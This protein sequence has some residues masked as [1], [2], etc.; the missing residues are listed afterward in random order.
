MSTST[1]NVYQQMM[2]SSDV[3]EIPRNTYQRNLNPERVKRMSADFD[4]RIANEPKVSKRNGKYYVFDGQHIIAARVA[5]NEGKATPIRCK[6]FKG[7]NEKDEAKLFANQTG[8]SVAPGIGV[9]LRALVFA[10]DPEAVNFVRAT[11]EA[12]LH[13]DF[14]QHKGKYRLAC[15]AAALTEYRKLGHE[16]YKEALRLI[17]E[18]WDGDQ[19]SLR[20]ETITSV[21]RFVDLYDG[22]Y[23][24]KRLV[25]RFR[26]VD[27]MKI[28]R[29][30]R[31]LGFNMPGYKKYL[32]QV[33]LIYNGSSRKT[34]LPIKF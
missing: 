12:G 4:E 28:Y 32:Y 33:L 2:L 30:G 19:D 16:K 15:I 24:P 25:K 10:E 11:E 29:D 5:L 31:A 22:E 23:D 27:P 18:G 9:K 34:A 6:V 1:E 21:C 8:H 3:L 17:V 14:G 26:S 13:I 20:A 7:L